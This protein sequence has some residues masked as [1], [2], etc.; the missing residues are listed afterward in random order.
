LN[1]IKVSLSRVQFTER[2]SVLLT[3]KRVSSNCASKEY[4]LFKAIIHEA[5]RAS[6]D[7]D[8][9]ILMQYSPDLFMTKKDYCIKHYVDEIEMTVKT[10][11]LGNKVFWNTLK[12]CTYKH[13]GFDFSDNYILG[14]ITL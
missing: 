1:S 9:K 2:L 12:D 11:S 13:F 7:G 8:C 5:G 10:I 4:G 14:K 3:D 6:I